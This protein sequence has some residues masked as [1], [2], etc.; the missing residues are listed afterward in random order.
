MTSP[1]ILYLDA[2]PARRQELGHVLKQLNHEVRVATAFEPILAEVLTH[3]P[4]LVLLDIGIEEPP[5]LRQIRKRY[6]I[7][8]VLLGSP[9]RAEDE[10]AG[11]RMGADEV[12][13]RLDNRE[14]VL[15]RIEAALRRSGLGSA[16]DVELIVVGD[17]IID[18]SARRVTVRGE[19]V[20]LSEREF[21]LLMTLAREAGTV[22]SREELLDRVW[23]HDFAGEPQ[24]LYVYVSW[25]R[26]K[27]GPLP[28]DAGRIVTVHRH[29]YKLVASPV[30]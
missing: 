4:V 20:E 16:D 14:L 30:A 13:T 29:G 24:T 10:I 9:E 23:G 15:A 5:S 28:E 17:L 7:P 22:L 2:D 6:N 26:K 21:C 19:P 8:L 27:L 1:C 18:V 3:P 25:L 11:L 12:L